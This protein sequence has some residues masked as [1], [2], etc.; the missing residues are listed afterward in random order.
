MKANWKETLKD[1]LQLYGHR[2]WLVIADSAYPAQSRQAI[3]TIVVDEE[4]ITVLEETLVVLGGC[5]HI[6]PKIYTDKE[7][8]FVG[9]DDAPGISSYRQKLGAL[10]KGHEVRTLPHEEIISTLDRVGE[11]FRVLLIK[12]NMRIPYTSVFLELECGYWNPDAENRLRISMRSKNGI[13]KSL[14]ASQR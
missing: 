1:R 4:Q 6:E 8:N 7:L 14:R 3:E 13:R 12:T 11:K 5:K 2:N 10:L 9:D